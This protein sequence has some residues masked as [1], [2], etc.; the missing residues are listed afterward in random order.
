[1][2]DCELTFYLE[3]DHKEEDGQESMV[4]PVEQCEIECGSAPL[5]SQPRIPP[6]L[7]RRTYR[8]VAQH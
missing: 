8:Q 5:K 4:D 2:T 7:K 6:G 3:P 1:M